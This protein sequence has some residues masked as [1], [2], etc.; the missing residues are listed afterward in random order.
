MIRASREA[1]RQLYTENFAVQGYRRQATQDSRVCLACLALSGTLH[2][3]DEIMPT[4]PN[5]RCVLIPETLSWAEITGDSSIPD[6]RPAV[7]T[8]DRILAGLS[9]SDKMAIMG[10][11][12]YQM[13]LDGKPLADFVQVDQNQDW[14]PTTRVLPLRSLV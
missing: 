1:Q 10:P 6:T 3:T 2:K 8:P 7:A 4:H 14:G 9:E 13:Y 12:R 5:C 11:A